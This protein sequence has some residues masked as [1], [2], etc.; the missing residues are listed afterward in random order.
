MATGESRGGGARLT[1]GKPLATV[2]RGAFT[3]G[4]AGRITK[5]ADLTGDTSA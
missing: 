3:S 1:S 5:A 2:S 4:S